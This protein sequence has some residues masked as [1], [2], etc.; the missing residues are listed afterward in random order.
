MVW[1][2]EWCPAAL[3]KYQSQASKALKMIYKSW[4]FFHKISSNTSSSSKSA[5]VAAFRED[6]YFNKAAG[7]GQIKSGS[8][9]GMPSVISTVDWGSSGIGETFLETVLD[10]ATAK[11]DRGSVSLKVSTMSNVNLTF[12]GYLRFPPLTPVPAVR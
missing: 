1:T 9:E 12:Y 8:G 4:Y 10:S 5:A 7:G 2:A 11:W 3:G 6:L